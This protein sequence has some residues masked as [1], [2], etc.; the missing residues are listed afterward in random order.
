MNEQDLEAIK[1]WTEENTPLGRQLGYP[2][3]CIKAFCDRPPEMLNK[4]KA[5]WED[6]LRYKAGCI[7]GVF[8]GFIPC[9]MCAKHVL[10]GKKKLHEL[11]KSRDPKLPAFPNYALF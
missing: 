4:S 8:T 10:E 6:F 11:I 2:E 3:C 5:T 7:D 1:R 9:P